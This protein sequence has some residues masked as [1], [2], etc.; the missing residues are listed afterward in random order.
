MMNTNEPERSPKDASINPAMRREVDAT[1]GTSFKGTDP[2]DTVSVKDP[3][4]G[5][6]WP[7]IWA[8]VAIVCVLVAI[9]YIV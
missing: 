6:S 4:E 7:F 5:R 9:Y 2:M 3:D 1:H 8:V